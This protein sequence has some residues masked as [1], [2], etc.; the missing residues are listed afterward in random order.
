MKMLEPGG[1]NQGA[2]TGQDTLAFI[3]PAARTP[4]QPPPKGVRNNLPSP[5]DA[6][7]AAM[8]VYFFSKNFSF[9]LIFGQHGQFGGFDDLIDAD[10]AAVTDS[11][12]HRWGRGGPVFDAMNQQ[13]EARGGGRDAGAS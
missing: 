7:R 6:S 2:A 13:H 10:N 11:V 4:T 8:A 5:T 12:A 1:I 9:R 3:G